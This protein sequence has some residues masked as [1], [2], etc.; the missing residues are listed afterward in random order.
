MHARQLKRIHLSMQRKMTL[1][2]ILT[3][4]ADDLVR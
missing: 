4:K 3:I 1:E 2:N